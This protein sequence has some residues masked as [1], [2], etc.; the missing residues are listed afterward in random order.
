MLTF[1]AT[2]VPL[3]LWSSGSI[4]EFGVSVQI[5]LVAGAVVAASFWIWEATRPPLPG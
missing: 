3:V 4:D 5:G 1:V 2:M